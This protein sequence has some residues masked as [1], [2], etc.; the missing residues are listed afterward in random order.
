MQKIGTNLET[1]RE[2]RRSKSKETNKQVKKIESLCQPNGK[3]WTKEV[4]KRKI[5]VLD[6]VQIHMEENASCDSCK[7]ADRKRK[8]NKTF[9]RD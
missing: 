7:T 8:T 4:T 5:A 3:Q 9:D 6:D 1:N 2:Y